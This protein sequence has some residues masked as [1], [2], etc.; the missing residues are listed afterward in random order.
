MAYINIIVVTISALLLSIRKTSILAKLNEYGVYCIFLYLIFIVYAFVSNLVNG[1]LSFHYEKIKFFHYDFGDLA[2]AA[3]WG[4]SIH[5]SFI[6]I[7]R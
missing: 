5:I 4:F 1:N 2:S 6:T 3:S 7:L